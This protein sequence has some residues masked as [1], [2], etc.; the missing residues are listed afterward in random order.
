MGYARKSELEEALKEGNFYRFLN[1]I[2]TPE[3]FAI[4]RALAEPSLRGEFKSVRHC[5]QYFTFF[6]DSI[7]KYHSYSFD[8]SDV[9]G[10]LT[11]QRIAEKPYGK[12]I[13]WRFVEFCDSPW[14]GGPDEIAQHILS[15][16]ASGSKVVKIAL[17]K[18]PEFE[19]DSLSKLC[20]ASQVQAQ[21]FRELLFPNLKSTSS[22]G[23]FF[24][25]TFE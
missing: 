17:G 19:E 22:D 20:S 4:V 24:T 7:K 23:M 13:Y 21:S 6:E 2:I 11:Y 15:E 16:E 10:N 3:E 8:Q 14:R 12:I 9:F 5:E 1:T 18:Y 25:F